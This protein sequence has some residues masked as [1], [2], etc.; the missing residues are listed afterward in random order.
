MII[1]DNNKFIIKN[2]FFI[3][4]HQCS[5]VN[6]DEFFFWD[7]STR[8][9]GERCNETRRRRKIEEWSDIENKS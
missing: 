3:P 8:K 9:I 7:V 5:D 1:I 6:C 2:W 4:L